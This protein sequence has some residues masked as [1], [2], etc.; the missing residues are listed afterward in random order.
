M[1]TQPASELY[2]RALQLQ[3]DKKYSQAREAFAEL[4]FR[5]LRDRAADGVDLPQLAG[6][7]EFHNRLY[8]ARRIYEFYT[9]ALRG[10][11]S[12]AVARKLA[13]YINKDPDTPV[14]ERI[15]RSLEVLRKYAALDTTD[16][17]ETL[18]NAGGILKFRWRVYNQRGDL[19]AAWDYYD[20]AC[21]AGIGDG[22]PAIN[23]AYLL[24]LLAGDRNDAAAAEQRSGAA[25]IRQA[26]IDALAKQASQNYW[27]EVTL[28]E[29]HFGLG[30]FDLAEPYLEAAGK[31]D[32]QPEWRLEATTRQLASL[33]RLVEQRGTAQITS[34]DPWSALAAL[35]MPRMGN[36]R[37]RAVAVV[38]SLRTGK[39]GLALSGGGFRASLFHLGALARFAELGILP[40][41][42]VISCVSG[43]S[44]VGAHYYLKLRKLLQTRPEE[45]LAEPGPFE[46]LVG[47]LI[48]KFLRGVQSNIRVHRWPS[49]PPV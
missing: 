28:A 24:D 4:A 26:I 15:Q 42:E 40:N 33:A 31:R 30:Q 41:V 27:T 38:A 47:E 37:Q 11:M 45:E 19:E 32:D 5:I 16:D 17:P 39:V 8:L 49:S 14:E 48:D 29:A 13:L 25:R 7:L 35:L 21:R 43:G 1:D 9:D 34:G 23:S 44:I 12:A 20:R 18:A 6:H 3:R 10:S 2:Q 22:Y 36:D 46:Q